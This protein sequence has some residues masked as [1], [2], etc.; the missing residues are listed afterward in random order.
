MM[1]LMCFQWDISFVLFLNLKIDINVTSFMSVP[2]FFFYPNVIM[3]SNLWLTIVN[4]DY[5]EMN[6]IRNASII[7][8]E[9]IR[10]LSLRNLYSIYV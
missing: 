10:Q 2:E 5:F 8:M 6:S 7:A 1:E 9:M 3:S 4:I